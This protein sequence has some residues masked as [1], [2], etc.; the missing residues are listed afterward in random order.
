M[1]PLPPDRSPYTLAL[2]TILTLFR[3]VTNKGPTCG[4]L[5]GLR[6]DRSLRKPS[7]VG[8]R[9]KRCGCI[10]PGSKR[11]YQHTSMQVGSSGLGSSSGEGSSPGAGPIGFSTIARLSHRPASMALTL[12]RT[13][14]CWS[15]TGPG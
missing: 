12:C 15:T 14:P 2:Y 10:L 4:S 13:P 5:S 11:P 8:S 9:E 7:G 1:G 6:K 3:R